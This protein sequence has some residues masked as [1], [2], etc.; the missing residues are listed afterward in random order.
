MGVTSLT[1]NRIFTFTGSAK[2]TACDEF[3]DSCDYRIPRSCTGDCYVLYTSDE[4]SE[5]KLRSEAA[6]MAMNIFLVVL[7]VLASCA[8]L[9]ATTAT[10]FFTSEECKKDNVSLPN[11]ADADSQSIGREA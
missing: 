2:Q 8:F 11:C 6:D 10:I 7:G 1:G 3:G 5:V 9:C 4:A